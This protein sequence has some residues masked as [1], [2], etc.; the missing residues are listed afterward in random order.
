MIRQ[1]P[2]RHFTMSATEGASFALIL[3]SGLCYKVIAQGTDPVGE[4]DLLLYATNG[5]LIQQDTTSGAGA[6][7]GT[8][9]PICPE[10]PVEYRVEIRA[11]G[12]GEVAT[13]LYASP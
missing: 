5:V 8:T 3:A 7:I 1:G 11:S 12:A 4:L 9:R 6:I 13:Q 10:D 2:A